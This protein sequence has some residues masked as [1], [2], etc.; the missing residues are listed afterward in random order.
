MTKFFEP[1]V[2][3]FGQ[4]NDVE[5]AVVG[6]YPYRAK[7]DVVGYHSGHGGGDHSTAFLE[8]HIDGVLSQ[9][10]EDRSF[11]TYNLK[12]GKALWLERGSQIALVV[13]GGNDGA[14]TDRLGVSGWITPWG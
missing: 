4:A 3:Q 14:T 8:L 12:I 7:I 9:R 2:E 1:Q 13:K 6:P 5:A 10:V 11:N